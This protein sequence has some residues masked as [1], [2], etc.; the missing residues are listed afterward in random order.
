M[1]DQHV[2]GSCS[3]T[4]DY[5]SSSKRSPTNS[6]CHQ[7]VERSCTSTEDPLHADASSTNMVLY[8]L[9]ELKHRERLYSRTCVNGHSVERSSF[10]M[11]L[12]RFH[13]EEELYTK[14]VVLYYLRARL[15][16]ASASMLWQWCNDTSDPVL[17]ENNRVASEWGCIPFWSNCIVLIRPVLLVSWQHCCSIDADAQCKRA[18]MLHMCNRT[19]VKRSLH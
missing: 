16:Y 18:L 11:T 9:S 6:K 1:L 2:E 10:N 7:H 12:Y 14:V 3:S 15:H 4:V 5:D 17:I 8:H 13:I 19:P